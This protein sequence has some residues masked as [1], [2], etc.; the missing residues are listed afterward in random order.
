[1]EEFDEQRG[2]ALISIIEM[3]LMRRKNTKYNLL[4]AKLSS[5]YDCTIRDCYQH[6]EY[7]RAVLKEVYSDDYNSIIDDIKLHLG[8]LANELDI[9]NFFK[10]M[11]S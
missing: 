2:I 1:L 5:H 8:D 10:V 9:A 11:E 4:V 6:P 3:V 7:L